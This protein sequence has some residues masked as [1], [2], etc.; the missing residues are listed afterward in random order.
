MI[1]GGVAAGHT[2]VATAGLPPW[3]VKLRRPG[4]PSAVRRAGWAKVG[5]LSWLAAAAG[6]A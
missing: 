1:G 5:E 4:G 2:G 6:R 3:P